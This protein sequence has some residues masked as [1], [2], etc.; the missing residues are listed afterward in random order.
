[1]LYTRPELTSDPTLEEASVRVSVLPIRLN[2]DQ[3][4]IL[5]LCEY[6][7]QVSSSS[8]A[9]TWVVTAAT[10]WHSA[11]VL[12]TGISPSPPT[13][14]GER[15]GSS[16]S[17]AESATPPPTNQVFIK[18]F[19]FQPDLPIR[20]DY[21]A[22]GFKTEIV[23]VDMYTCLLL[24]YDCTRYWLGCVVSRYAYTGH[25]SRHS[26]RTESPQHL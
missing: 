2:I 19:I 25:A 26:T 14:S 10:Y 11:S 6:I 3:D 13:P 23:R 18:S 9:G 16:D 4:T 17:T 8:V 7:K 1:M 20:I 24:V 15:R 5:F 21:E 12:I 22:K